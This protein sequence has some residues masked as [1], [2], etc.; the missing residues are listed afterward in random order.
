MLKKIL[1]AVCLGCTLGCPTQTGRVTKVERKIRLSDGASFWTI[2]SIDSY[3]QTWVSTD[4]QALAAVP[5]PGDKVT[6]E[7]LEN[8]V[9]GNILLHE[10]VETPNVVTKVEEE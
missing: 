10:V 1:L 8:R 4:L 7:V 2:S 5:K 9:M 6:F 3:G